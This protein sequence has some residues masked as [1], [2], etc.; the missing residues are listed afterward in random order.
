MQQLNQREKIA[1]SEVGKG[2]HATICNFFDKIGKDVLKKLSSSFGTRDEIIMFSHLTS[3]NLASAS[4][5][6]INSDMLSISL[7]KLF[8]HR[9]RK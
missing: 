1:S 4:E 6:H 9:L 7:N 3:F 8:H 5:T 2:A